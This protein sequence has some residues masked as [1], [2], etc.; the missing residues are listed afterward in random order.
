M[1]AHV[2][3]Q[4]AGMRERLFAQLTHMRLF[5]RERAHVRIQ[6]AGLRERLAARHAYERLLTRIRTHVHSQMAGPRERLAARLADMRLLPCLRTH[7]RHQMAWC[8]K[9][10]RTPCVFTLMPFRRRWHVFNLL[11]FV[12]FSCLILC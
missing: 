9:I 5:P 6:A 11:Q 4:M 2:H 12:S 1:R 8:L 7:V 10:F 3:S